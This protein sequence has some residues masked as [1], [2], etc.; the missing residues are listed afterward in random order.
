M[1]EKTRK[2]LV[3]SLLILS[4]VWA[5]FH[6]SG[7]KDKRKDR[8]SNRADRSVVSSVPKGAMGLAAI[9]SDSLYRE[10]ES[11]PWGKDPFYHWYEPPS[12]AGQA[13]R[14]EARWHL[15]GVLFREFRAHALINHRIVTIGDEIDGFR[16]VEISRDS[17]ILKNEES[18]I[19]LRVAKESS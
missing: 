19:T 4:L 17:V 2:R 12:A 10:Y 13:Y 5:Y 6:F 1:S 11:R 3:F 8:S 14:E 16:V 9:I 18:T 7:P 15:L